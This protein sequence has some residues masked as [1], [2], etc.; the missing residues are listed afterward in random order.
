MMSWVPSAVLAPS[1][2]DCFESNQRPVVPL[3]GGVVA[4]R[5][6]PSPASSGAAPG[7]PL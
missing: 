5:A 4:L 6:G 2:S 3:G 1:R 7:L